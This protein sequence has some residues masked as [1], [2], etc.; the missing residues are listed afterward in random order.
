MSRIYSRAGSFKF[1]IQGLKEAMINE[2]NFQ[3]HIFLGLMAVIFGFVLGLSTAEWIILVFTIAFVLV[4]ELFNT[5]IEAMVDLLSPKRHPKA[6]VAKD[7][8]A[9]AVFVSSMVA[10]IVALV[11]FAPKI[12]EKLHY[13]Q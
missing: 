3:I 8:S 1:A 9:A 13:L 4:L 11:L 7:V 2:P 10:I 5:A 12:L 6:K